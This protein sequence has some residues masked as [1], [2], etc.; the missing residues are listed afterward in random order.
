MVDTS[1][2]IPAKQYF[3][4]L[5]NNISAEPYSRSFAANQPPRTRQPIARAAVDPSE[6]RPGKSRAGSVL[7]GLFSTP[8]PRFWLGEC[9]E[10][11]RC[12][13]MVRGVHVSDACDSSGEFAV[14]REI[15]QEEQINTNPS[16]LI[17]ANMCLRLLRSMLVRWV[18]ISGV[19]A[20]AKGAKSRQA[21]AIAL[22]LQL[23]RSAWRPQYPSSTSSLLTH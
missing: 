7:P 13:D 10:S 5:P 1:Q 15:K 21:L 11:G 20:R 22:Y 18:F 14:P 4:F 9:R 3:F 16:G 8:S 17:A 23:Y 2:H 6:Q 19:A 12:S